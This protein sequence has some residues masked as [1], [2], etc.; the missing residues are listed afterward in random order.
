M[1]LEYSRNREAAAHRIFLAVGRKAREKR[2]DTE[3]LP[4]FPLALILAAE[5]TLSREAR[6]LV[7][8]RISICEY[9]N[10]PSS[11]NR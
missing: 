7:G 9:S 1:T 11:S 8:E 4:L 10:I 6:H 2:R 5:G 3:T